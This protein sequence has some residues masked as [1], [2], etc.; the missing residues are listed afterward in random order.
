VA[1]AAF[2]SFSSASAAVM[3][4]T[5]PKVAHAL[6]DFHI[7]EI[8]GKVAG[9]SFYYY[10]F[11]WRSTSLISTALCALA[12]AATLACMT[13]STGLWETTIEDAT[14]VNA[15]VLIND[16]LVRMGKVFVTPLP[17]CPIFEN[18]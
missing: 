11:I 16:K 2:A 13:P 18:A 12:S 6:T 1:L 17:H 10:Y 5:A 4:T 3:S 8:K 7:I 9:E 15:C 14:R